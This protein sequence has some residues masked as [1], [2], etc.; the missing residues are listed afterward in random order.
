[1]TLGMARTVRI[2]AAIAHLDESTFIRQAIA[3][4]IDM[5]KWES[6]R[7]SPAFRFRAVDRVSGVS[8]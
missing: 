2:A 8:V 5:M 3:H 6:Q 4:E 7:L 1:M